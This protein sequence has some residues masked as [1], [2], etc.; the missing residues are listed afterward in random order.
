MKTAE[1]DFAK[2]T[3]L[4]DYAR[5]SDGSIFIGSE[6]S[7]HEERNRLS[8]AWMNEVL[9]KEFG[10]QVY[11][12]PPMTKNAYYNYIDNVIY[13][14]FGKEWTVVFRPRMHYLGWQDW[15]PSYGCEFQNRWAEV[16]GVEPVTIGY[17]A[18]PDIIFCGDYA[19]YQ[20]DMALFMMFCER[21]LNRNIKTARHIDAKYKN[22]EDIFIR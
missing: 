17:I 4:G 11:D 14:V 19:E 7:R 22:I 20:N 6:M 13:E 15:N 5:Y 9:G 16:F 21:G 3:A 10:V 2:V 1:I 8:S 12:K 18:K